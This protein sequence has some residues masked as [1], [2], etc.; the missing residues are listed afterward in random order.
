MSAKKRVLVV[1]SGKRVVEAALPVIARAPSWELAGVLSRKPKT[2]ASEGREHEVRGL[3]ELTAARLSEVDLVYMVVAKPA[4]PGVL[5]RFEAVDRAGL[6]MLI[7][8]PV[9]LV[10]HLGHRSLLE[11]FRNVWVSED[12]TTLPV[13]DLLRDFVATGAVGKLR[14]ATFDRSAYAYHGM[15]MVKAALGGERIRYARQ[16]PAGDGRRERRIELENGLS[17]TIFDPRDYALGTMTFEAEDGVVSDVVPA[18]ATAHRIEVCE[19]DGNCTALALGD[20]RRT[21]DEA[22][23]ELMGSR[24]QGPGVTAWM[25]GM[26]RVGFQRL[27]EDVAAGRGAYPLGAALEDALVDYFLEKLGRWRATPFTHPDG[28][29][30]R[31]ALAALT[32]IGALAGR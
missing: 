9:M 1:G 31:L 25:D 8:T 3:E 5:R 12:C 27:F 29:P 10:R 17:A 28:S 16:R 4:V 2:I 18:G 20:V 6:D 7:E 32:R 14:S 15:A 23:V 22:E 30:A 19:Q 26:K 21:F 24:G 11:P 13:L